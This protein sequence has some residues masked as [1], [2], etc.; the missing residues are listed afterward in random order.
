[1]RSLVKNSKKR[2]K[3]CVSKEDLAEIASL[4]SK[5]DKSKRKCLMCGKMFNSNGPFNRRCRKCNRVVKLG[6]RD[7]GYTPLVYKVS[8]SG[9]NEGINFDEFITISD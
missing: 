3:E 8:S 4:F 5:N 9:Y 6:R 2:D 7:V 1:M